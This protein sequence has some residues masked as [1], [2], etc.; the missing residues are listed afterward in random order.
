MKHIQETKFSLNPKRE[1]LFQLIL[2]EYADELK[3]IDED[4]YNEYKETIT[5]L[6]GISEDE[7]QN[8]KNKIIESVKEFIKNER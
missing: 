5:F 1:K 8:I 7:Y 3:E 2:D 4:L 6:E